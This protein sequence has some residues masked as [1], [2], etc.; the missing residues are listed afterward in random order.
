MDRF[1]NCAGSLTVL[2]CMWAENDEGMNVSPTVPERIRHVLE[3][4]VRRLKE[5]SGCG[6]R[7]SQKEIF[8]VKK[9]EM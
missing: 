7:K 3:K 9:V 6:T 2:M 1:R 5:M 4:K 8:A